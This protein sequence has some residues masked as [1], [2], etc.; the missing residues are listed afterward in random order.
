MSEVDL[1]KLKA[2]KSDG[3]INN[4][5]LRELIRKYNEMNYQD[6]GSWCAEYLSKLENSYNTN[7]IKRSL[8]RQSSS[9]PLNPF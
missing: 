9:V 6:D 7:K 4:A 2:D 3:Y 5:Y 8:L 1:E